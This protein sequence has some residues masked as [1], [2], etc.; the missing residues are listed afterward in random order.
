MSS[1][2][3]VP[4][5]KILA[6]EPH[7]GADRL[8][9][10]VV[11]G[12]KIIVTK[13]AYRVGD[14]II[15]IPID[16]ILPANI[17]ALV[18]PEG[19]KIKL[20]N[21]RVRQIKIRG[22]ASQGL[23]IN[24]K[25][26]ASIVNS[27]YLKPEQD[28][29]AILGITRYEPPAPRESSPM[30]KIGRGRKKL[31][32]PDFHQYNGLPNVKWSPDFFKAEEE[33]VIQEKLHGTN[34][35]AA[36]MI[37][38]TDTLFRKLKKWLGLSPATEQLYGSNRV[39]ISN[40]SSYKGFYGEDVY[41]TVFKKLDVFSKLKLGETVFGEIV[42]PG[43]QKGYSYGLKEHSFVLFD[44]KR[45]NPDGTQFWLSPEGVEDFAA[46]RGFM[47]VPILYRGPYNAELAYS[48]TKGKTEFNDKSEKVREGI[49]IKAAN[50]Y[51]EHGN[52]RALKWVSE[53]YLSNP[54]N[55]DDH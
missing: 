33:V 52:K 26:I 18:F 9:I 55:T 25:D 3:K 5:T 8:E 7:G 38:R 1:D 16:S 30:S 50:N 6:I 12:F 42:G 45:L 31:A 46:E 4:Y 54:D 13:G 14:E 49:V 29:A 43:I 36:L 41:G 32:H 44:V 24:P 19:S 34:A 35:R 53:D 20:T 47:L 15:L 10:A 37:Y 2:Y 27:K 11:F 51:S 40:A 17:E 28:L 23:I 39:D 22:I 21:S 48:L